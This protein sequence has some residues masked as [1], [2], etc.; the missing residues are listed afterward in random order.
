[1]RTFLSSENPHVPPRCVEVRRLLEDFAATR[2]GLSARGAVEAHLLTCDAC[3]GVMAD[4]LIQQV[5]AGELPLLTP[6]SMPSPAV[7]ET[8]LR[9]RQPELSWRRVI[10]GM[11]D[12]NAAEWVESRLDEIRAG[13][14]ALLN[15]AGGALRP[16]GA[17]ERVLVANLLTPAGGPSGT[18]VSFQVSS[19]P[20][21]T[22]DGRFQFEV[23]TTDMTYQARRLLC[24]VALPAVNPVI[25]ETVIVTTAE[26][27]KLL[28]RFNDEALPVKSCSLPI[29]SISLSMF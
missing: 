27:G 24:T 28:A 9:A 29:D 26:T 7:Y 6:P 13:F 11:T 15:P 12:G 14:A 18:T 17:P 5:E 3:S 8:Y 1:M 4:M 16:R 2:L 10:E 23:T 19:P 22:A 20:V 21:I 25:F